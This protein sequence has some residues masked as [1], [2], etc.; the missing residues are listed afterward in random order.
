MVDLSKRA[1]WILKTNVS[2]TW[3]MRPFSDEELLFCIAV[4]SGMTWA[5]GDFVDGRLPLLENARQVGLSHLYS[6]AWSTTPSNVSVGVYAVQRLDY[7]YLLSLW[8]DSLWDCTYQHMQNALQQTVPFSRVWSG[9]LWYPKT[10]YFPMNWF[11]EFWPVV[12]ECSFSESW[13]TAWDALCTV[14]LS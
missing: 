14:S 11:M 2:L 6:W 8:L 7:I 13:S 5:G 1:Q 10:L 9:A 3:N 12:W 4:Q